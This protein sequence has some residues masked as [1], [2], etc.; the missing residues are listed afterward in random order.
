MDYYVSVNSETSILLESLAFQ[1]GKAWSIGDYT[2][3]SFSDGYLVF[4]LENQYIFHKPND[5]KPKNIIS[6]KEAINLLVNKVEPQRVS[7]ST[8]KPGYICTLRN[9]LKR[10]YLEVNTVNYTG[11]CFVDPVKDSKSWTNSHYFN[12]DLTNKYD[13]CW[14]IMKVEIPNHP[15]SVMYDYHPE[16]S[17]VIFERVEC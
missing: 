6:V 17:K 13:H 5:S 16:K 7:L 14:D 12:E 3:R 1:N 2:I 11:K 4:H 10:I 8:L 15:Y 9:S